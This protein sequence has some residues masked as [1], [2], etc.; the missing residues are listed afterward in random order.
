MPYGGAKGANR[1]ETAPEHERMLHQAG[2]AQ[3]QGNR[4]CLGVIGG[5]HSALASHFHILLGLAGIRI[6]P[7]RVRTDHMGP[8]NSRF[9]SGWSLGKGFLGVGRPE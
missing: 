2:M 8:S 4:Q 6:G 5:R 7:A 3:G 9:G 1:P